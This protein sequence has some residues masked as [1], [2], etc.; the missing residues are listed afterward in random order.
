MP[1]CWRKDRKKTKP[2]RRWSEGEV[3]KQTKSSAPSYREEKRHKRAGW[4]AQESERGWWWEAQ[5][6]AHCLVAASA[7]T[8]SLQHLHH[9]HLQHLS[10]RVSPQTWLS[11]CQTKNY[12][13]A[14]NVFWHQFLETIWG[15]SWEQAL[16]RKVK[17]PRWVPTSAPNQVSPDVLLPLAGESRHSGYPDMT[18][19]SF[20]G[21]QR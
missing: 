21:C 14:T 18:L 7:A 4:R 9:F 13:D 16:C 17:K 12:S 5:S 20:V 11:S 2:T 8:N 10:T 15:K 1:Q 6:S 3:R 19:T